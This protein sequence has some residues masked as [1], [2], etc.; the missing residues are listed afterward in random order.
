MG[1]EVVTILD[2]SSLPKIA[3]G[4]VQDLYDID[5]KTLLF[6]TSDRISAYNVVMKNGVPG[7]GFVLTY[8]P[9]RP[10]SAA[11][12]LKE[13][14]AIPGGPIYTPSTKAPE[15]Q[16]DE[17]IHPDEAAKLVGEKYAKRIE[18]LALQVFKAE[19]EYAADR[20]VIIADTK[21]EFALDKDEDEVVLVDEVLTPDSSRFWPIGEA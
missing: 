19:Q 11:P 12:G 21:F 13:Y 8:S 2:I 16:Y 17:N 6:V 3:S 20:G 9:W 10:S 7:K 15:G 14:A 5:D 1:A 18:K 4:K